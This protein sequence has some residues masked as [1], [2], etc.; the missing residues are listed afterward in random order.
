MIRLS[1][2]LPLC[3][4]LFAASAASAAPGGR[5]ATLP[6]GEYRCEL[7]GDAAGPSGH[8]VPEENFS[9]R[10]ASTYIDAGG[11][12][13]YLLT[14]E[15]LVMTSGPKRGN[16]YRRVTDNFLRKVDADGRDTSLRCVRHSA[17]LD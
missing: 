3:L 4:A 11:A 12:G 15:R 10:N 6:V 17:N 9:I 5:L 14:G 13:S 2:L 8:P 16:R 7:P 1:N